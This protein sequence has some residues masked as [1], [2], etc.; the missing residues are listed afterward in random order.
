MPNMSKGWRYQLSNRMQGYMRISDVVF[1]RG[2]HN[3]HCSPDIN[4]MLT[5]QP[6][7]Q[8]NCHEDARPTC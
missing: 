4:I 5:S 8:K 7:C 3:L 2:L 1:V 6:S